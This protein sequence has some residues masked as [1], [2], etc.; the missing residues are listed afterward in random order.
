MQQ[1]ESQEVENRALARLKQ[2]AANSKRETQDNGVQSSNLVSL[3]GSP[4]VKDR[5]KSGGS[6]SDMDVSDDDN[7]S[8]LRDSFLDESYPPPGPAPVPWSV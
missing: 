3:T 6:R 7:S 4:A 8:G 5:K 2:A 1:D